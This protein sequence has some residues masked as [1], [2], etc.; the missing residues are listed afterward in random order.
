MASIGSLI[1]NVAANLGPFFA[2]MKKGQA[3]LKGFQATAARVSG[4]TTKLANGFGMLAG[5]AGIGSVTIA[6]K[7]S[8]DAFAEDERE[9]KLLE[10]QI[11]ATGG[12]A[13]FTAQE[14]T[15]MASRLQDVTTFADETTVAAQKVLLSFTNIKGSTFT[16]AI[17]AAQ[18]LST[19]MGQ[20]LQSSVV[21]IGKALQ[22]PI[23]GITA[24]Q[25]VGVSFSAAQKEVIKD[26]VNTGQMAKA[27]QMILA[28]LNKEFGGA[29]MSDALT[30][31]GQI[32]QMKNAF[33]DLGESIGFAMAQLLSFGGEGTNVFK[34]MQ[35][36][37]DLLTGKFAENQAAGAQTAEKLMGQL[38]KQLKDKD[39]KGARDTMRRISSL[40]STKVNANVVGT[41][42]PALSRAAKQIGEIEKSG[43]S[44]SKSSGSVFDSGNPN[45]VA[46]QAT[47]AASSAAA[48]IFESTR[49]PAEK[50]EATMQDLWKHMASG[51]IDLETFGRAAAEAKKELTDSTV[52]DVMSPGEITPAQET[53][54]PDNSPSKQRA[55]ALVAGSMEAFSASQAGRGAASQPLNKLVELD[56]E[57]LEEAKRSTL[58]MRDSARA[59]KSIDEKLAVV[60]LA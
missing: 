13:G 29:A 58:E 41:I 59:L 46:T 35:L 54:L 44:T 14:L 43:Q 60:E 30:Y 48:H 16:G 56:K 24:L 2:G 51:T 1:V 17:V 52:T 23:K 57:M 3:E 11:R 6:L 39:T 42:G 49:T 10:S 53:M 7:K 31:S 22:D 27:Q 36:N 38:D 18:N 28:E 45:K 21:Q 50:F 4:A 32:E 19:I 12:A 8:F 40:D 34:E 37:L 20:D 15:S 26:L 5:A 47:K 9:A 25:R 33:G 55:G